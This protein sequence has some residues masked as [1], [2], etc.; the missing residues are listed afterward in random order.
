MR[1]PLL[2]SFDFKQRSRLCEFRCFLWNKRHFTW[3]R[4]TWYVE[5]LLRYSNLSD[6]ISHVFIIQVLSLARMHCNWK[7]LR[8]T[9][10]SITSCTFQTFMSAVRRS[11]TSQVHRMASKAIR[12]CKNKP[13]KPYFSLEVQHQLCSQFTIKLCCCCCCCFNI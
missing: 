9:V 1:M 13:K 11:K 5:L 3:Q 2:G 12:C 10:V 6:R 4:W 7:C 8:S